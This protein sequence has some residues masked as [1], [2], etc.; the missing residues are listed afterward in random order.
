MMLLLVACL[1]LVDLDSPFPS[2]DSVASAKPSSPSSSAMSP[3]EFD[4]QT[5]RKLQS[6][7]LQFFVDNFGDYSDYISFMRKFPEPVTIFNKAK[8]VKDHPEAVSFLSVFVETQAFAYFLEKHHQL[9]C[10]L[11]NDVC[12]RQHFSFARWY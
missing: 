4:R 12:V 9:P 8:F 3:S 11:F 7:F 10:S 2:V 1:Q 6:V 5:N